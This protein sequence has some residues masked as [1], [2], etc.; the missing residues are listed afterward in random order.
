LELN[1]DNRNGGVDDLLV[2][3]LR[4]IAPIGLGELAGFLC[5]DDELARL[6]IDGGALSLEAVSD[7][8]K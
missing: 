4:A 5:W 6:G 2:A 8:N 7:H 1:L 3:K